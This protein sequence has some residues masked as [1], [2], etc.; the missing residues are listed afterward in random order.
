MPTDIETVRQI[1][2]GNLQMTKVCAKALPTLLTSGQKEKRQE[3]Y[4]DVL[5]QIEE[6]PHFLD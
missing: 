5:K 1:L 6:N 3:I 4:A 2:H